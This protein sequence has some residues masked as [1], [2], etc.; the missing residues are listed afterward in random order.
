[1]QVFI[2]YRYMKNGSD[3]IEKCFWN[4]DFACEAAKS[5]IEDRVGILKKLM[6]FISTMSFAIGFPCLPFTGI[7]YSEDLFPFVEFLDHINLPS[8]LKASLAIINYIVAFPNYYFM[9]IYGVIVA[10]YASNSI[11]QAI[12][13]KWNLINLTDNLAID[14]D[15][16]LQDEHKQ[17]MIEYKLK[18]C[19]KQHKIL[20]E[21][22]QQ[23]QGYVYYTALWHLAGAVTL[24]ASLSYALAFREQRLNNMFILITE[25]TCVASSTFFYCFMA[26]LI[27]QQIFKK[28]YAVVS[29]LGAMK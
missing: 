16:I 23:A 24:L 5:E 10:F 15:N 1:M 25:L 11:V 4:P 22:I 26:D 6:L 29:V 17:M 28:A 3:Y 7:K 12:L 2:K 13:I 27:L 21:F 18:K 8:H 19:I 20:C 14:E 9:T